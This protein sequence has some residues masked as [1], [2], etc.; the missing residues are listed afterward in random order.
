MEYNK[1]FSSQN[2]GLTVI[3]RSNINDDRFAVEEVDLK[4]LDS[5]VVCLCFGG[6]GTTDYVTA[7][8]LMKIVQDGV[9]LK[10]GESDCVANL[11]DV[12]ILCPIYPIDGAF[13]RSDGLTSSQKNEFAE[14]FFLRRVLN[15]SGNKLLVEEACKNMAKVTLFSYCL[16]ATEVEAIIKNFYKQMLIKGYSVDEASEILGNIWH[17]SFAPNVDDFHNKEAKKMKT[18]GFYSLK[19]DVFGDYYQE[20]YGKKLNGVDIVLKGDKRKKSNVE[21]VLESV[22]QGKA[23][24]LKYVGD[25]VDLVSFKKKKFTELNIFSSEFINN[26]PLNAFDF[27]YE[28]YLGILKRRFDNW[29]IRPQVFT[30][31]NRDVEKVS[32]NCDCVSQMMFYS[33][34]YSISGSVLEKIGMGKSEDRDLMALRDDLEEIRDGFEEEQLLSM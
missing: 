5:K 7:S 20:M 27:N 34:A 33:L 18:I 9:G 2:E 8:K 3:K 17:I 24:D 13:G 29:Q 30:V 19:D 15:E 1:N 10:S 16:G 28:H 23:F 32:G 14:Q 6:N 31:N 22:K 11:S 21:E 26:K 12:D 4:T 25:D